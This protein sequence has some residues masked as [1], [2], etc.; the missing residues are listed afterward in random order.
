MVSVFLGALDLYVTANSFN[1]PSIA[2]KC[3]QLIRSDPRTAL[4]VPELVE[5]AED[6]L[7]SILS[8]DEMF[9]EELFLFR[10]AVSWLRHR[11]ATASSEL[12]ASV[13]KHVRFSLIAK[14]KLVTE[15]KMSGNP[16][17]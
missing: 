2:Q 11:K 4:C 12:T 6:V 13:L 14:D 9:V 5:L 17:S 1:E 16:L 3:L 15:V 10:Q 7:V 8:D